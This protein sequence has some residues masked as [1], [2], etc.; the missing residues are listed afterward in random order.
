[1][2]EHMNTRLHASTH[3]IK[4]SLAS[5][6]SLCLSLF[7]ALRRREHQHQARDEGSTCA[8]RNMKESMPNMQAMCGAESCDRAD[9]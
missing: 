2:Y 7:L 1:M 5:Y 6:M 8:A 4:K 3:T 9:K